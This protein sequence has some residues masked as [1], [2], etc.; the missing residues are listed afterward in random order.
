MQRRL[1]TPQQ[2]I[3]VTHTLFYGASEALRDY[4]ISQKIQSLIYIGHPLLAENS[5]YTVKRFTF[6]EA[7]YEKVIKRT[8]AGSIGSYI[9]DMWTTFVTCFVLPK[10]PYV[11]IGVN[12]LNACVGIL[13]RACGRVDRVI[14]YSI[15]FIPKRSSVAIVNY[16]YHALE[17]FAV[18][19]SDVC[20]NVSPR[21][22]EGRKKFL[23]LK[24]TKDK[25]I[26]VPIGVWEKDI[27]KKIKL[28]NDYR[29]IFVGHLLE[30]QGV[31]KVIRAMPAI[32]KKLPRVSLTI[33]GGGEY[34]Q[35]LKDLVE[36]LSL[37]DHIKFL[38]WESDQNKIQTYIA[39]SDLALATYMP[40]GRDTT[41]FS[42]YADPTKIKTYLSCGVPVLM[43]DVSY[44]AKSLMKSGVAVVVPYNHRDIARAIVTILSD[45][46]ALLRAKKAAREQAR[47]FTWQKIFEKTF[48]RTIRFIY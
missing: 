39:K 1:N 36:E 16:I 3:I 14:F 27:V 48:I 21:I 40:S 45:T 8:I 31:Q 44:N 12:P 9:R 37:I 4:L 29:L 38:G 17:S 28:K 43:T 42:Y 13:L 32:L 26:V 11:Y 23:G 47:T 6:G 5:T 34:E 25:Q 24:T 33:I 22:E 19:R 20:W 15:D 35:A 41:N 46:N 7:L 10:H 2:V 18:T 30:K